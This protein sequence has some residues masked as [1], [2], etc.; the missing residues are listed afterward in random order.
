MCKEWYSLKADVRE[1]KKFVPNRASPE[2]GYMDF[3]GDIVNGTLDI[4]HHN[5]F[6]RG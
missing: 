3:V 2:L 6:E 4:L 1:L 5:Y